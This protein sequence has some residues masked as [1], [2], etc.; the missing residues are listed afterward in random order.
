M[1]S[2]AYTS[3]NDS[4]VLHILNLSTSITTGNEGE[5]DKVVEV[6]VRAG[7]LIDGIT[8]V[9]KK[10]QRMTCGGSGGSEIQVDR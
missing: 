1:W 10:G 2:A 7:A 9:T 4:P 5:G 8:L 6:I 3:S